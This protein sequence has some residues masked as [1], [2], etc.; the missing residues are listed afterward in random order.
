MDSTL[1]KLSVPEQIE[2]IDENQGGKIEK[3]ER[4]EQLVLN[5]Y[6]VGHVND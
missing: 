4:I 1:V 3:G 5:L 6:D 2:K